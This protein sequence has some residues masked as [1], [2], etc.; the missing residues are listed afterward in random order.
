MIE[1]VLS[2]KTWIQVLV[3]PVMN[4]R[5]LTKS[6]KLRFCFFKGNLNPCHPLPHKAIL[7]TTDRKSVV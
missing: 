1:W 2:T 4:S 5:T 6:R 3:L 7:S